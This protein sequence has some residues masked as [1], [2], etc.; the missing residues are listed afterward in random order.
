MLFKPSN[1]NSNLP[2][3]LGYLNPALNNSALDGLQFI[4]FLRD[5]ESDLQNKESK[6]DF[7]VGN[8]ISF[9]NIPK[10][11]PSFFRGLTY[12]DKVKLR[13]YNLK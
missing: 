8:Y 13:R 6:V 9:T 5:T 11:R 12:N 4:F 1:L 2:L 3:T 7:A 10:A